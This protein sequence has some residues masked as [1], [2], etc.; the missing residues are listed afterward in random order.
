MLLEG[1]E[2]LSKLAYAPNK[3]METPQKQWIHLLTPQSSFVC[4][5]G[6]CQIRQLELNPGQRILII[7][8]AY[9]EAFHF[10][11]VRGQRQ[12]IQPS[13]PTQQGYGSTQGAMFVPPYT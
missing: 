13:P 1:K 10:H 9:S 4:Q 6:M 3:G 12:L 2:S 5:V 11:V 8:W 7:I